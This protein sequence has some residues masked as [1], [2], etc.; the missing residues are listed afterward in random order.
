M[1][2]TQSWRKFSNFSPAVL[3]FGFICSE[4]LAIIIFR[5]KGQEV[6]A[7][8]LMLRLSLTR[9][10]CAATAQGINDGFNVETL[11][12]AISQ[13]PSA[14]RA[15]YV[16][17]AEVDRR[18]FEQRHENCKVEVQCDGSDEE[19]ENRSPFVY[20]FPALEPR[21]PVSSRRHPRIESSPDTSCLLR[22]AKLPATPIETGASASA[23]KRPQHTTPQTRASPARKRTKAHTSDTRAVPNQ[24]DESSPQGKGVCLFK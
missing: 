8:L 14:R 15:L 4:A 3:F 10:D 11:K 24:T 7:R 19:S 6:D 1:Y 16:F 20:E 23:S 18:R 5:G 17:A 21:S 22:N 2:V 13:S 12:H 9:E